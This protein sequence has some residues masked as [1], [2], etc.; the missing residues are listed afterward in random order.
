MDSY[1]F[2][3]QQKTK[4]GLLRL[5]L[6]D[7]KGFKKIVQQKKVPARR[8]TSPAGVFVML[9]LTQNNFSFPLFFRSTSYPPDIRQ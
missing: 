8:N 9:S 1:C 5:I 4:S 6:P 2:F 7:A 3:C